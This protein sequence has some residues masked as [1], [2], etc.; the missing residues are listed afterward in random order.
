MPVVFLNWQGHKDTLSKHRPAV[1]RLKIAHH[2]DNQTMKHRHP[3]I[4]CTFYAARCCLSKWLALYCRYFVGIVQFN[5]K[6]LPVTNLI[7]MFR[8][9]ESKLIDIMTSLL[10]H[11]RTSRHLPSRDVIERWKM[12]AAEFTNAI[13]LF[14]LS[15]FSAE[16][17]VYFCNDKSVCMI[18]L[19][20]W[21]FVFLIRPVFHELC[22]SEG[23]ISYIQRAFLNHASRAYIDPKIK[24]PG[25]YFCW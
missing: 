16:D 2:P 4:P 20:I 5:F 15:Y 9:R 12:W 18:L 25:I 17:R 3:Y 1:C 23:T 6:K 11:A 8:E 14:T 7:A 22:S 19:S 10:R 21:K 24:P 13:V